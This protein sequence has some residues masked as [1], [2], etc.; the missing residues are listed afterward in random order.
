MAR[1]RC[2]VKLRHHPCF[3]TDGQGNLIDNWSVWEGES[4]SRSVSPGGDN[5]TNA[6]VISGCDKHA[7]TVYEHGHESQN[8]TNQHVYTF[9]DGYWET[10]ACGSPHR[11]D[12]AWLL[13]D[14]ISSVKIEALPQ[15]NLKLNGQVT[16]EI[17]IP[18]NN[19]GYNTKLHG[20]EY[21]AWKYRPDGGQRHKDMPIGNGFNGHPCTKEAK[22]AIWTQGS[23][24]SHGNPKRGQKMHCTF[25]IN[26]TTIKNLN[27]STKSA[28]D[29]R[30]SMYNSITQ[31]ICDG[32]W[33]SNPDFKYGDGEKTCWDMKKSQDS[34][35]KFCGGSNIKNPSRKKHC[36][37]QVLG[38]ALY[39]QLAKEFCKANPDDAFCG[40]FNVTQPGLCAQA[41][42]LPGCKTVQPIWD[43]ITE[44]LDEGDIAQFEG[45][46]ACYGSVCSGDVYQPTKWD[47][48]CD[49][50]ISI[51]K[52]DFDIGGDLIDSNI[53]LKQDCGN[54]KGESMP[55]ELSDKIPEKSLIEKVFK[56][57]E[58]KDKKVT[59][60][61]TT[62]I[63][64]TVSSISSCFMCMIAIVLFT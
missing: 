18:D 22:S 20:K 21:T 13:G 1:S 31:R 39:E 24:G 61:R 17:E 10:A 29:P 64:G 34:M 54:N 32:I 42:N 52:A 23:A 7:V 27:E 60:K 33:E 43:K 48:N 14:E 16:Y 3:N 46:Q 36:N 35:E 15:D 50:D 55:T 63:G 30:R 44:S 47:I 4:L 45:M 26:E 6:V 57:E 49:R 2:R 41:P 19:H 38:E 62:K 51:C 56:L 59:E 12:H 11:V 5:G 25:D 9:K 28:R 40:C 58:D 8:T 37:Q 53:N